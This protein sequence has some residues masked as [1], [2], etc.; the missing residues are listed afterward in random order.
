MTL[1]T[2]ADIWLY[3]IHLLLLSLQRAGCF[4][5]SKNTGCCTFLE[6]SR[7]QRMTDNI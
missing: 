3:I 6:K 5:Y 4:F 7:L 1:V 2:T